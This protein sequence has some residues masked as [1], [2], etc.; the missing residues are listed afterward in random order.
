MLVLAGDTLRPGIDLGKFLAE[1]EALVISLALFGIAHDLAAD[2][3]QADAL[4][5]L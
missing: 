4:P 3:I 2:F 5:R 1:D